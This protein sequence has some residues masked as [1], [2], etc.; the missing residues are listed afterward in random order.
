LPLTSAARSLAL[1]PVRVATSVRPV[2]SLQSASKYSLALA[3][4]LFGLGG[5]CCV[6]AYRKLA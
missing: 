1:R 4:V 5:L 2:V 3:W 6:V